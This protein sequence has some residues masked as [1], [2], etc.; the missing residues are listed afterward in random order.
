MTPLRQSCE[1]KH[2]RAFSC[3]KRHSQPH[4]FSTTMPVGCTNVC[5][6]NQ[7]RAYFPGS[8]ALIIPRMSGMMIRAHFVGVLFLVAG[9][10]A[11]GVITC[12]QTGQIETH[13]RKS[14]FFASFK[15]LPSRMGGPQLLGKY[16]AKHASSCR[17]V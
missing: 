4:C 1:L 7:L 13:Y 8:L 16:C 10:F 6:F 12:L 15:N 3:P 14:A 2:C 11:K 9:V 5:A 17:C